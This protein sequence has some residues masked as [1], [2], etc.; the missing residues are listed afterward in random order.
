MDSYY[1]MVLVLLEKIMCRIYVFI[2][3]T[4]RIRYIMAD[5]N[6]YQHETG[7]FNYLV[8]SNSNTYNTNY[9]YY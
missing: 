5:S 6:H 2:K 3:S 4:S 8:R 9:Y 7:S 1:F